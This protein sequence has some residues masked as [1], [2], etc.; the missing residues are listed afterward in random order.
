[1]KLKL[2]KLNQK[3]K[4]FTLLEVFFATLALVI[5]STILL[6]F[7]ASAHLT[8]LN[9]AKKNVAQNIAQATLEDIMAQNN[10]VL[11][12]LITSPSPSSGFSSC[13]AD[14]VGARPTNTTYH[15]ITN[16]QISLGSITDG[17]ADDSLKVNS[18][19]D[20]FTKTGTKF[21]IDLFNYTNNP[22]S[23][24]I[25]ITKVPTS[26]A[27]YNIAIT[28]T[29]RLNPNSPVQSLKIVGTKN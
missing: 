6:S 28:V 2:K 24:D 25:T 3:R 4:G 19:L 26:P 7:V 29:W 18:S 22:F 20:I 1:M 9:I 16:S 23:R 21:R 27:S 8:T 12:T 5:I 11:D 10:S 17:L 14:T 15:V 13:P